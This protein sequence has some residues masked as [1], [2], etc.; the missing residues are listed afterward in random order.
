MRT[1][2]CTILLKSLIPGDRY[3]GDRCECSGNLTSGDPESGCRVPA[4]IGWGV[5]SVCSGRGECECGACVCD[6]G[7]EVAC[8]ERCHDVFQGERWGTYTGSGASATTS[9]VTGTSQVRHSRECRSEMMLVSGLLCGGHGTCV[10]RAC[11]CDPGWSGAACDCREAPEQCLDPETQVTW[12][13][14]AL[15]WH[16][17]IRGGSDM[18]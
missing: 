10:C 14:E 8:D 3:H 4:H 13:E 18:T 7:E 17:V 11:L 15:T 9:S 16:D 12:H 6:S 2:D 1:I 5:A